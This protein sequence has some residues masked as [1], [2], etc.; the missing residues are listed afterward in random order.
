LAHRPHEA[1]AAIL[2][3]ALVVAGCEPAGEPRTELSKGVAVE[4]EGEEVAI[5]LPTLQAS[6]GGGNAVP[7][8]QPPIAAEQIPAVAEV[9]APAEPEGEP[10][11]SPEATR[12]L[13]ALKE[14]KELGPPLVD[15]PEKL[16]RLDPELPIWIDEDR[17]RVVMQ[18]VVCQR[19][20][21]LELFAC[22]QGTKEYESVVSVPVKAETIHA[23]LLA[24]G[25]EPGHPVQFGEQYVA[26]KG[27]II[28]VSVIWKDDQGQTRTDRAQNWVRNAQTGEAMQYPWVFVGSQFVK[29]EETGELTYVAGV[30]GNLICVSN[31]PDA[32]LDIPVQSTDSDAALV[33][34]S[35][36]ERIPPR[37]TPVTLV[38]TP[39]R[40]NAA[41]EP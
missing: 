6:P 29:N 11:L 32:V 18:G 14:L 35:F 12:R 26:A 41:E 20:S 19:Q 1:L 7:P 37:G 10:G 2:A 24:T 33:Y 40:E 30:T 25:V 22:V 27:P 21:P 38:L 39:K 9:E 36:T 15:N 4:G 34:E 5:K 23:A 28:E 31:F 3:I 16:K 13:E 8:G 17:S